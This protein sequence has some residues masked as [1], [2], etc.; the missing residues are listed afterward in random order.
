MGNQQTQ[1]THDD[2]SGARLVRGVLSPLPHHY[3]RFR[4][5]IGT[6]NSIRLRT[7]TSAGGRSVGYLQAQ[8]TSWT[9]DYLEQT[10]L[11]VREGPKLWI[12][13]AQTQLRHEAFII[14]T[15]PPQRRNE[16]SF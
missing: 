3:F 13:G 9:K 2:E 11:V 4:S 15:I 12:T 10:Q 7:P 5:Q 1:P 8:P 16:K 14:T 6:K